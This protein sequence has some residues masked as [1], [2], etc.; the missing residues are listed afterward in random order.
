MNTGFLACVE[1]G[2]RGPT[3]WLTSE[4][5]SSWTTLASRI[6]KITQDR[7]HQ[8]NQKVLQNEMHHGK[9]RISLELDPY[10]GLNI[11]ISQPCYRFDFI[12]LFLNQSLASSQ[13]LRKCN[14]KLLEYFLGGGDE[15]NFNTIC[16]TIV[17]NTCPTVYVWYKLKG[18]LLGSLIWNQFLCFLCF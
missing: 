12:L 13:I 7:E 8:F 14:T 5:T 2:F 16:C 4:S 10:Q 6:T 3:T 1:L 18:L 11:N 9:C 17:S 15:V